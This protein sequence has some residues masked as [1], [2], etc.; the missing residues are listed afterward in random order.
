MITSQTAQ[1]VLDF[2]FGHLSADDYGQPRKAWFIKRKEFDDQIRDRFLSLH[3]R[4]CRGELEDWQ[5]QPQ[6]C[7]A[8]LLVLDQFSRNLFR[9]TPQA[10]EADP[11]ALAIAKQAVQQDYDRDLL[12]VQRWFIYLPF[13]HSESWD[14]Q[15]MSL[16]LWD[17][18]RWHQPSISS[19]HYAQKHADVIQRF[20]RF[21]HRNRI[22]N[23]L[24]TE[25]ELSFL[26]QPG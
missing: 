10:F 11:Q 6:S 7:L 16:E 3:S 24:S 19:I 15:Q 8:L 12:P 22:L 17:S 9:G 20:G 1:S 21:P 25:A 23:R 2:W 14:D 5:Q 18:L 13:E 4:A 26:E